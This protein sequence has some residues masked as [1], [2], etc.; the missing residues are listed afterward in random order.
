MHFITS[1]K[2]SAAQYMY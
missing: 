1:G 2:L